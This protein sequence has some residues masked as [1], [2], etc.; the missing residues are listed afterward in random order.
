MLLHIPEV[1]SRDQVTQLRS[2]LDVADW[3][4]GRETVG[5]QGA[6]VKRNQ[7]LPDASP[8]RQ[9]LGELGRQAGAQHP[10]DHAAT[11]PLRTAASGGRV[12]NPYNE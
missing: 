7:L 12:P 4:D 3:T 1:L 9:K 8:L 11:L 5:A 6:K 10:G 2:A